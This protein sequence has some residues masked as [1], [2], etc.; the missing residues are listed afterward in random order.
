MTIKSKQ[1]GKWCTKERWR[2]KRKQ[3]VESKIQ[4]TKRSMI[5]K[6]KKRKFKTTQIQSNPKNQ[7]F[8]KKKNN[9]A[10]HT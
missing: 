3:G 4:S 10:K 8:N 1:K 7:N 5:T 6:P 2:E 9:N